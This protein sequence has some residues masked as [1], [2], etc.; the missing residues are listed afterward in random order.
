MLKLKSSVIIVV[1]I[2]TLVLPTIPV[3]ASEDK[4][5]Q[6]QTYVKGE[7]ERESG[8]Y[9][10]DGYPK[11]TENRPAINPNFAPDESCDL[12]WELKCIPGS[13]QSC[14]DLEGYNNGEMNVC[15]PIG[16]PEG[17]HDNFEWEDNVCY[18]NDEGCQNDDYILV[19]REDEDRND[20][21]GPLYYYCDEEEVRNEDFCIEYCEENPDT[22]ACKPRS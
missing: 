6:T 13:Q 18:S 14:R 17:Y 11:D 1:I 12:K 2:A 7:R 22:F 8:F 5:E 16:C 21:C 10:D 3:S 9:R 20:T 15:T 4:P 19:E